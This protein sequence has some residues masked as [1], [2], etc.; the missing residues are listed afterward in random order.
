[1]E[2]PGNSEKTEDSRE[3]AQKTQN[4]SHLF[5]VLFAFLRPFPSFQTAS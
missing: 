1:L 2:T 5:C 4:K 3:K